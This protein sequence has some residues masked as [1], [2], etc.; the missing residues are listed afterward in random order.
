METN[1]PASAS[2]C[3]DKCPFCR[4]KTLLHY[5]TK[6][7]ARKN[8]RVL[9]T[10]LRSSGEIRS[11]GEVGN[12]Y[13][14]PG[15][16][17]PTTGWEAKAGVLEKFPVKLAAA[18][19]HL[20]PGKASMAPSRVETWTLQDKAKIKEDVGY[21][22]DCPQNGLFLPHLPEIYFTRH[23]PGTGVPMSEFYG[24][25]W[26]GLSASSKKSIGFLVMSETMLQ[27]HYT[28]HDDPYVHVDNSQ[29]YDDEC[30]EECNHVA[31]RMAAAEMTAK[32]QD[33][34]GKL[35]PPYAIVHDL[36]LK[37]QEVRMRI[38][39]FPKRWSSWVSPLAQDLTHEL[40]SGPLAPKAR[41]VIDRLTG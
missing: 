1:E 18:P 27:M 16:G 7:G 20:L 17:D 22:I 36:N 21:N 19:H 11:D 14:L 2:A 10:N 41:G 25:T 26:S 37:S 23:A 12:V 24:Q 8:E 38:T 30:K 33:D 39:G 28:D 29:N 31:D 15:G 13:P 35:A 34:D 5:R 9:A 32:C 40:S 3:S 4:E 6:N